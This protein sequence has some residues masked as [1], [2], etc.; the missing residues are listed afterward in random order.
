VNRSLLVCHTTPAKS[1]YFEGPSKKRVAWSFVVKTHIPGKNAPVTKTIGLARFGG[2]A[3][4]RKALEEAAKQQDT[5]DNCIDGK[6][7][8][9]D[10]R[11][12]GKGFGG[13][14]FITRSML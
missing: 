5:R 13:R 8:V 1:V 7:D 9:D 12:P 10:L 6:M 3:A 2:E 14:R 4:L 11:C